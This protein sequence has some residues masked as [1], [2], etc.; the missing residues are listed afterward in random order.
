MSMYEQLNTINVSNK[1]PESRE[2]AGKF[3]CG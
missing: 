3:L 1:H 2:E